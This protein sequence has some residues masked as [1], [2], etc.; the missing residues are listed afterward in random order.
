MKADKSL[1]LKKQELKGQQDRKLQSKEDG[2]AIFKPEDFEKLD[3]RQLVRWFPS[4]TKSERPEFT[5][6]K[7]EPLPRKQIDTSD[8]IKITSL[9][10]WTQ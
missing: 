6:V 2:L 10:P 5:F 3:Q 1:G 4:L 8:L 9:P 7:I